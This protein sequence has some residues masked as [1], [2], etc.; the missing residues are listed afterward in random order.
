MSHAAYMNRC[1]HLAQRGEGF[2]APNPLVGAVLVY[3]NQVIGEGWHTAYGEHHAEV[4]CFNAVAEID[5][6]LIPA[7]TLYVNLEPCSHYGKTP[8]CAARIIQEGIKRVVVAME[9]PNPLVA[10]KGI[11]MLKE[12]GIDV[13]TGIE[14]ASAVQLNKR[15]LCAILEQKPY[16]VLKWAQTPNGFFA[17]NPIAKMQLSSGE[18]AVLVHQWRTQ[19]AAI[20][21]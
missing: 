12:A 19:E 5:K 10:G 20:F 15:F 11:A 8:P 17:P 3:E 2:T 13:I 1:F 14:T 9:D 4:E 16:I 7:A 6:H 18:T 21:T